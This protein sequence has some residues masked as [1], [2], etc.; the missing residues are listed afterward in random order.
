MSGWRSAASYPCHL[1]LRAFSPP[2]LPHRTRKSGAPPFM[3]IW[4]CAWN[5]WAPPP[6]LLYGDALWE[7]R[8]AVRY[9][10]QL[11]GSELDAGGDIE[12][13]GYGRAARGYAHAAVVVGLAVED[14]SGGIIHDAYQGIVGRIL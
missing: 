10:V 5:G 8:D 2:T 3:V 4:R 14:V 13:C 9:H 12:L 6:G 11:A 7:R 1:L